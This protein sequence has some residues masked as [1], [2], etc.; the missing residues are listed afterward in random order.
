MKLARRLQ[1]LARTVKQQTQKHATK[2]LALVTL[3]TAQA[4]QAAADTNVMSSVNAAVDT[5][6]GVKPLAL[7]IAGTF[8]AIAIGFKAWKKLTK[9]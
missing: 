2:G 1:R 5:Y 3:A 7:A 9:S 8:L 4:A 6:E